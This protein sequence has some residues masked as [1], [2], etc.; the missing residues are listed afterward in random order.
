[1]GKNIRSCQPEWTLPNNRR[2]F[3]PINQEKINDVARLIGFN[4]AKPH[5]ERAKQLVYSTS[6]SVINT[7]TTGKSW[8]GYNTDGTGCISSLSSEIDLSGKSIVLLG[9]GGASQ[10]LPNLLEQEGVKQLFVYDSQSEKATRLAESQDIAV[11]VPTEDEIL[12]LSHKIDVIIDATPCGMN[13]EVNLPLKR[14]TLQKLRP[15]EAVQEFV[16]NPST[17]PIMDFFDC[18]TLSGTNILVNQALHSLKHATGITLND[19]EKQRLIRE[20]KKQHE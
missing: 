12:K 7:V 2:L 9:A 18:K 14:K 1:M 11:A 20:L 5:K 3:I 17:T 19:T 15:I 6:Y 10:T 4:V 16:Y 13:H 8:K